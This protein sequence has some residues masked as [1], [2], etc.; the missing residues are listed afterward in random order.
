MN[1]ARFLVFEGIDGA[2]KSTQIEALVA[3][4]AAR[5]VPVLATR[6]PG[7][8]PAG[9]AIRELVLTQPMAPE[10]ELLLMCAAR[11][12]HLLR[13][14]VPALAAGTWV[15][16]DRF[17]DAS[18]AYQV[19]GRGVAPERFALLDAWTRDGVQP[20][21][22]FLFDL[23]P[24]VAT[25]RR[26]GREVGAL[27]GGRPESD[28]FERES[29]AFFARVRAAY[30]ERAA[31]D[32]VRYVCLDATRPVAEL[33]AAVIEAVACRWFPEQSGAAGDGGTD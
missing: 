32:P 20:D 11:R 25:A 17:A 15:V 28:R 18:Y 2:G 21:L 4:L 7:G 14:I 8:T 19:G 29:V 31:R 12:E 16:S 22:T 6:E 27:G 33:T 26:Q 9:E 13:R 23:P 5:A 30:L 24:E 10:T 1:P 3:W